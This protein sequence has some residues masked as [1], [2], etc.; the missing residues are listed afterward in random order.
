MSVHFCRLQNKG[1]YK[2]HVEDWR[3]AANHDSYIDMNL[4]SDYLI[5]D[6][7]Q[8]V[9]FEDCAHTMI[10]LSEMGLRGEDCPCCAGKKHSRVDIANP[11]VVIKNMPN[12]RGKLYRIVDGRHRFE[13][14]RI[15][16][17]TESQMYVIE[18]SDIENLFQHCNYT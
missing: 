6:N 12:P 7:L 4:L 8:T 15:Q 9:S 13:K 16:G 11:C 1:I 3:L 14:M 2:N 17:M 10:Y 18:Y 5:A